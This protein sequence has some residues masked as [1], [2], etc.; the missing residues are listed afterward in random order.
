[1]AHV[2]NSHHRPRFNSGL[3]QRDSRSALFEGYTGSGADSRRGVTPSPNRLGGGYGY[4]YPGANG[5]AAN[6]H[7]GVEQRGFRPATPNKKSV[8]P[9]HEQ[10][11][12]ENNQVYNGRMDTCAGQNGQ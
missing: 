3:H 5:T 12:Y 8:S 6:G 7:L 11:R 4:G 9:G 2:A 10:L 1:M